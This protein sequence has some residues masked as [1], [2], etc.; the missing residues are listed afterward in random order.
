MT[1]FFYKYTNNNMRYDGILL[2]NY[3]DK[4][5]GESLKNS[6]ISDK[7]DQKRIMK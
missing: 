5:D 3:W 6:N 1:S 7:D 4:I 2:F